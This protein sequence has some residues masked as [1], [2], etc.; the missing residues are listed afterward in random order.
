MAMTT[1]NESGVSMVCIGT[2]TRMS[3]DLPD[4]PKVPDYHP[5]KERIVIYITL[6]GRAKAGLFPVMANPHPTP[7][8]QGKQFA[9]RI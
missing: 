1:V 8:S 5:P 3:P 9:F 6:R 4:S 2:S 7:R